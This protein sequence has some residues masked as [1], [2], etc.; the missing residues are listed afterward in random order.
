MDS[1]Q[2]IAIKYKDMWGKK[3]FMITNPTY[4]RWEASIYNN[5]YPDTEDELIQM[6][7]NALKP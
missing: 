4:G 5:E 3:W 1:R 2:K 6:R 7:M